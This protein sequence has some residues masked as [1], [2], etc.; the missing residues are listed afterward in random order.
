MSESV[1]GCCFRAVAASLTYPLSLFS[2]L[3]GLVEAE[4]NR[5][6][7]ACGCSEVDR[8]LVVTECSDE[9]SVNCRDDLVFD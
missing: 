9:C 2:A 8:E 3:A 4:S 5:A 6:H 1:Q 7:L